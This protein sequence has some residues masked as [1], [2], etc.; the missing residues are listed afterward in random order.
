MPRQKI[1][2]IWE[3]R[4]HGWVSERL[5]K[6]LCG[7]KRGITNWF[8]Q[9]QILTRTQNSTASCSDAI[10]HCHHCTYPIYT[11]I[12]TRKYSKVDNWLD[13]GSKEAAGW[14]CHLT[15]QLNGM[16]VAYSIRSGYLFLFILWLKKN[17][18]SSRKNYTVLH[19]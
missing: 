2:I 19:I 14:Q 4:V 17:D 11:L 16:T 10:N 5:P 18:I 13:R 15:A 6:C 9:K 1:S 3:Q 8:Q 12:I 7:G